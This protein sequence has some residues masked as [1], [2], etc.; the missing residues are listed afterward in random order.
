MFLCVHIQPTGRLNPVVFL[1]CVICE[2]INKTW[3]LLCSSWSTWRSN[4]PLGTRSLGSCRCYMSVTPPT[5]W[6]S[7]ELST[8]TEK[9]ASAWSIWYLSFNKFWLPVCLYSVHFECCFTDCA[10]SVWHVFP[11]TYNLISNERKS[12]CLDVSHFIN[13]ILN[14]KESFQ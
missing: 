9:S 8:A 5:L 1:S 14:F 11:L 4:Q 13:D 7:M 3:C 12:F 6:A 10:E 2:N